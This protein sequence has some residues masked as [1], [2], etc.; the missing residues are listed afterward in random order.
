MERPGPGHGGG[1]PGRNGNLAGHT[2]S[3]RGRPQAT[4]DLRGIL[5]GV[6]RQLLSGN[7]YM[8]RRSYARANASSPRIVSL[9][10]SKLAHLQPLLG[11][12]S[13][14]TK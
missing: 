6:L 13:N 7:V 14:P 2:E 1:H 5:H 10:A 4:G 8:Q 3:L 12:G 11:P 9:A